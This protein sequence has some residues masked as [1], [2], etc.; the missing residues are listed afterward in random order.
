MRFNWIDAK[1]YSMNIFLLFDRWVLRFLLCDCDQLPWFDGGGRNYKLDMA[2]ALQRYPHV[3]EFC[4]RKAPECWAFLDEITALF[5][6]NWTQEEM[7]EAERAILQAH[8]TF[9]V[10]ADPAAMNQVNYIRCWNPA[11]LHELV[12]LH[13]KLVLDV[14]AGTGRLAFEAAKTARR[15]YASEPCDMLREHMRDRIKAEGW[16]NIKVLDGEVM[17]L[18]YEDSTFDVILSGHVVGDFYE[19]EIA[20]MTRICK[21]GGWLVI[22]NGDDDVVR[23]A[24]DQELLSRGFEAFRHETDIGGVVYNYRKQVC[25]NYP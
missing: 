3:V 17:C 13:D 8:E 7:L 9:V 2:K 25:K 19:E 20:E 10:Y 1:D 24:P 11:R 5:D 16:Q 23:K 22:C 21:D 6:E 14:G 4:R 15:V 18:P 12:D